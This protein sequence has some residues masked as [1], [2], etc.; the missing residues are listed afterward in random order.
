MCLQWKCL[1][2]LGPVRFVSMLRRGGLKLE[3]PR[4]A[5]PNLKCDSR[6]RRQQRSK[7]W[8]SAYS[9][10]A[11]KGLA[12]EPRLVPDAP[13]Q[14]RRMMSEG[15]AFIVRGILENGRSG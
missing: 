6:R 4:G 12:G 14:E 8:V 10:L 7:I 13:V 2:Q 1:E 5:E 3:F 9:S 15:A 11:R